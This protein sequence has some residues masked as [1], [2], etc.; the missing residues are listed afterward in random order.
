MPKKAT[1][2]ELAAI[3]E[4]IEELDFQK[5]S[6]VM[7]ALNWRW[8]S[9]DDHHKPPSIAVM[10]HEVRKSLLLL[11]KEPV[12]SISETGGFRY[13]KNADGFRVAFEVDAWEADGKD[14]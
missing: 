2:T 10:Q 14:R 6:V 13:E 5:I 11:A 4:I 7:Y 3:E 8:V 1:T 12:G 9:H